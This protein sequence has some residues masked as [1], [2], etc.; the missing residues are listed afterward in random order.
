MWEVPNLGGVQIQAWTPL[1]TRYHV[2]SIKK[3]TSS[4]W[5]V[6]G[7]FKQNITFVTHYNHIGLRHSRRSTFLS[8]D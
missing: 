7:Y 8:F 1:S 6:V 3:A 2:S 5:V 4:C